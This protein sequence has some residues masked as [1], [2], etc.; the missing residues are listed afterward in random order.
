MGGQILVCPGQIVPND[1]Y[2]GD[3]LFIGFSYSIRPEYA[4]ASRRGRG[5]VSREGA[6]LFT[7]GA[8]RFGLRMVAS[9]LPGG[10]PAA[11]MTVGGPGE[12]FGRNQQFIV[13]CSFVIVGAEP[14]RNDE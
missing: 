3:T 10:R 8:V 5:A 12:I 13:H 9:F 2:R 4:G 11:G 7:R 1:A 6:R 14:F